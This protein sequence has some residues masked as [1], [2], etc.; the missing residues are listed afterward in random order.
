MILNQIIRSLQRA[1][2]VNGI[3][4]AHLSEA[5]KSLEACILWHSERSE[6]LLPKGRKDRGESLEQTALRETFEETGYPC[7]LLPVDMVTRAPEPG[8]SPR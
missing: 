1:V 8:V 2:Q 6:Y 7:K 4:H 5:R 3:D